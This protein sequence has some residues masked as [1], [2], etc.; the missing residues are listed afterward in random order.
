MSTPGDSEAGGQPN[1][2]LVIDDDDKVRKALA[3]M[4]QVEGF[5]TLEAR[6]GSEAVHQYGA[7]AADIV[8]ATLD[9][10]MPTTDGRET[11][12]MLSEFAKDLPIVVSTALPLPEN[13]L[14]RVPG[15]RGV[16]YL[17][18]P[19]SAKQL[20]DEVRRVIAEM[21]PGG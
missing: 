2:V 3:R 10:M 20:S 16:G 19:F 17:Q 15:S 5:A 21:R 6:N 1:T 14:G 7:H 8:A 11:L 9:L 18:K 4:L 12:A 13:L